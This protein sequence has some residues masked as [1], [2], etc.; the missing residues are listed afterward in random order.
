MG[1][2]QHPR[3]QHRAGSHQ[4]R[5]R[6]RAVGRR[7]APQAPRSDDAAAAARRRAG[8]RRRRGVSRIRC[9]ALHDRPVARD[10]RGRV[11]RLVVA[12]LC[13]ELN[14]FFREKMLARRLLMLVLALVPLVSMAQQ[15][16]KTARIG[17]LGL[18]NPTAYA[19][20]LDAFRSGLKELG[21]VE[22]KNIEIDYRW[23]DGRYERLRD[24]AAELVNLKVEVIVTHG[25]GGIAA[26]SIT[27]TIPIVT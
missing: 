8:H 10:R 26:K 23:A 9:R 17:V 18:A 15:P 5:F 7:R 11:G 4:D 16:A 25:T 12:A 13:N 3:E 19:A 22:G 20:Q 6:T 24:L 21:Y 1:A 27:S 14:N 2:A